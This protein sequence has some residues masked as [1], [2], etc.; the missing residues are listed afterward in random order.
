MTN[1][2]K[3]V[4]NHISHLRD[5]LKNLRLTPKDSHY[6]SVEDTLE[7]IYYLNEWLRGDK[8]KKFNIEIEKIH[9][10][11]SSKAQA[12]RIIAGFQQQKENNKQ[13]KRYKRIYK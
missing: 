12:Q 9:N 6:E 3:Q 13:I 7:I 2:E 1:L 4:K 10:F 11:N 8:K 5:S